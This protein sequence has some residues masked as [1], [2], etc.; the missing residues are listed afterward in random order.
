M[1]VNLTPHAVTLQS[2]DG[3]RF[4]VP[5]SGTVVQMAVTQPDTTSSTDDERQQLKQ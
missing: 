4:T 5:P 3:T 2:A 1:F